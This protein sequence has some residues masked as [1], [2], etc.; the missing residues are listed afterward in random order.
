M[1]K[2]IYLAIFPLLA[3]TGCEYEFDLHNEELENMIHV[4]C[5]AGSK[6]TTFI[7]TSLAVPANK[8]KGHQPPLDVSDMLFTVNGVPQEILKGTFGTPDY[9]VERYYVLGQLN[10]GDKVEF[11]ASA[12][13][14]MTASSTTVI[15][16]LPK[17]SNVAASRFDNSSSDRYIRFSMD[18]D[19]NSSTRFYGFQA[20]V[21]R[22]T[23]FYYTD[24]DGNVED[25]HETIYDNFDRTTDPELEEDILGQIDDMG[26]VIIGFDGANICGRY[27]GEMTLFPV[28]DLKQKK[29]TSF[30]VYGA[31]DYSREYEE[32]VF[33]YQG[34]E[35]DFNK[36]Q[37][38]WKNWANVATGRTVHSSQTYRYRVRVY[39]V[40]PEFYYYAKAQFFLW[41]GSDDLAAMGLTPPNFTYGNISGGM[42]LFGGVNVYMSD[43]FDNPLGTSDGTD[44]FYYLE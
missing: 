38:D 23:I 2:R 18:L 11:K 3:L 43:W 42:G 21:E 19:L 35:T 6:D 36:Q 24:E 1:K 13:N 15:P 10:S 12:T 41:N 39:S 27:L 16:E 26:P 4:E 25:Y 28:E 31:P 33:V 40:S 22:S 44:Y 34:E 37:A 17:V 29:E 8:H 32:T 5:V 14:A 30:Y 7:N 9:P 20:E